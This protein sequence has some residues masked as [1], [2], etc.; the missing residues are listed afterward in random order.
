MNRLLDFNLVYSV[1]DFMTVTSVGQT[2]FFTKEQAEIFLQRPGY[3]TTPNEKIIAVNPMPQFQAFILYFGGQANPTFRTTLNIE[4]AERWAEE[5]E[6]GFIMETRI[7][8]D[9]ENLKSYEEALEI[10]QALDLLNERQ[11]EL[12]GLTK[13]RSEFRHFNDEE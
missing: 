13:L 7:F 1:G 9:Q 2:G 3:N 11:L 5:L 12:L 8:R 4:Q 10:R 6:K